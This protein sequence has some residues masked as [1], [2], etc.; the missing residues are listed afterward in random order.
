MGISVPSAQETLTLSNAD[1]ALLAGDYQTAIRIY[2]LNLKEDQTSY[3]A[4]FGLARALAFSGKRK[5]AIKTFTDLLFLYPVDPDALLGRGRVFAWEKQYIEA[6]LDLKT[7]IEKY[8]TYV[9]AWSALGDVYLWS[10]DLDK[11]LTTYTKWVEF[12]SEEPAPYIARAKAYLAAREFSQAR[13]DLQIAREGGGKKTEIDHLIRSI[14]R[15][16][17]ATPWEGFLFYTFQSFSPERPNW[18]TYSPSL[19]R[20]L[21]FGSFRLIILQ[22]T[23]FSR[24]DELVAIDSYIDLWRRAYGNFYVQTSDNLEFLPRL[25]YSAEIFQGVGEGWEMSASYRSMRWSGKPV[26]IYGASV[27]KYTGNWYLRERTTFVPEADGY[28]LSVAVFVRRYLLTVDDFI[29]VGV[30][31]G[32]KVETFRETSDLERSSLFVIIRME[33]FFSSRMGVV[34]SGAYNNREDEPSSQNFSI[35]IKRRW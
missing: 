35:G 29:E 11:A 9:D 23:R 16:P 2:N 34:L 18:H 22:T 6:E 20:D 13:K 4:L 19:R 25:V 12:Q 27:A 5:E 17:G 8:P 7:V 26:S 24:W 21:P 32:D 14:D 33:R 1:S 15:I 3:R 30:G 10:G 31:R 28:S